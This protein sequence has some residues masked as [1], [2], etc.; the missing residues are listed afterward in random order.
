MI[1]G[2]G[3]DRSRIV[4]EGFVELVE[5][6]EG[7]AEV[8][9][10]V[11]EMEE[12]RRAVR[13]RGSVEVVG[14]GVG[15]F[16]FGSV[17]GLRRRAAVSNHVKCNA[18]GCVDGVDHVGA[19]RSPGLDQRK[20]IRRIASRLVERDDVFG[21]QRLDLFG[22]ELLVVVGDLELRGIGSRDFFVEDGLSENG[23]GQRRFCFSWHT[24]AFL[25][26]RQNQAQLVRCPITGSPPHSEG[27]LGT[28]AILH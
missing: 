22:V 24:S 26:F 14:D 25:S 6:I 3:Q 13:G 2:N 17:V 27:P 19:V 12:K 21:E 15:D 4:A 10:D 28:A 7:F 1:A 9:D 5:V 20:E 11:A 18:L 16:E 23:L 8:V